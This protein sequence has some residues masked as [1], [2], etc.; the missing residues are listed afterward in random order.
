MVV[1]SIDCFAKALCS[2]TLQTRPPPLST[3]LWEF[4]PSF[5]VATG[6]LDVAEVSE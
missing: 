6:R 1:M 2:I 3:H 4:Q 5:V